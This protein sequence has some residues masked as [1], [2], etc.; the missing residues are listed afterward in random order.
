M[1]VETKRLIITED[2]ILK[3][4]KGKERKRGDDMRRDQTALF[5]K[6]DLAVYALISGNDGLKAREIASRLR[7]DKTDI[8]RLLFSSPLMREL[9][10][11][12]SEYRWHALIRQHIPH[13]GLY[14]C[15]GW[16]GTVRE[17][18][19]TPEE[20]WLSQLQDG[21]R[22]IGRNLN[23]MRGL[24]HSFRDSGETMRSL[25]RDLAEMTEG[26]HEDWELVFEF[27]LNRA[28]MIRIYA[29]VLLITREKVFSL[30]FKMK[31]AATPEEIGQAAKYCP[32]LEMVF[33]RNYDI[34][35]A[36]VLTGAADLFTFVSIGET[37]ATLPVC[38]GDMLFNVLNEYML[39]LQN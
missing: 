29:D 7:L 19:N 33:G 18:L 24:I 12:D 4:M 6:E 2:S 11:Q 25:F 3:E 28:R 32:Y 36:L 37:D 35:P 20:T 5:P 13:E 34:L 10:Y 21:C 17:F 14:E 16:Y 31:N 23:D 30:E 27:R 15:S 9:C 8:S 39:F 38:S 22:R 26:G 1:R